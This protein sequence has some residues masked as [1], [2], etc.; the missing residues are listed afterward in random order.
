MFLVNSRQRYFSC[1][2]PTIYFYIA[3]G[4]ALS[5][6]YGRFF[7][8]FLGEESPVHLRLLAS[9]TGVGL[10]YGLTHS[11]RRRFSW[12]SFLFHFL[13]RSGRFSH[14]LEFPTCAGRTPDLPGVPLMSMNT[15]P[16][17]C[18]MYAS[19]SLHRLYM[20]GRNINRLSISC[21][22][23]HRLRTALPLADCHRQG[24]LGLAV[25][26]FLTAIVV[27]CANIL[28]SLRSTPVR[29][30]SFTAKRTLSYPEHSIN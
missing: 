18:E 15:N 8:E 17:T 4:K 10:R 9:P 11:N 22:F 1:V 26:R 25:W 6:S 29:T 14:S 3:G 7:A 24:N 13:R 27:T 20:R 23:R 16:I 5:R 30:V 28:T 2:P 21:G 12:R 19:P